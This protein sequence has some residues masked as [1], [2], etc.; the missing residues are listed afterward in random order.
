MNTKEAL[1]TAIRQKNW[2]D[3]RHV[4]DRMTNS[5]FRRA[6]QTVRENI[7]PTLAAPDF[8]EAWLHLII[9]RPQAFLSGIMA[10]GSIA[11]REPLGTDCEAAVAAAR[12]LDKAQVTKVLSMAIPQLQTEAQIIALFRLFQFDD[13]RSQVAVLIR[14]NTPLAYFMLLQTLQHIAHNHE[15]ALR[16]CR[17]I[18][19][20]GDDLSYNMASILRACFG[21][22]EITAQ[23]SLRIEPYEL[24][25][26]GASYEKF[27]YVL[28]GKRPQM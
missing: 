15:L 4:F 3:M 8:W 28:E 20:K 6:Q 12:T 22:T 5:E 9:Y 18:L 25:Y 2:E 26:L 23:L 1:A 21:L 16:C 14:E 11:R 13:E 17:Y 7:L 24:S 19:R 27:R 10:I